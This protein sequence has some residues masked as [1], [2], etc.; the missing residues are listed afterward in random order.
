MNP[1]SKTALSPTAGEEEARVRV[2]IAE[3]CGWFD[4]YISGSGLPYGISPEHRGHSVWHPSEIPTYTTSIDAIASAEARLTGDDAVRYWCVELPKVVGANTDD[5][6]HIQL[7]KIAGAS[8][9]SRSLA[10]LRAIE[11]QRPS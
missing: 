3:W 1:T 11:G 10:L 8:A 7:P 5:W 2:R 6:M 4:C 9:H